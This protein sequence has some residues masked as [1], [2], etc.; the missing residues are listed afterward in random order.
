MSEGGISVGNGSIF[1]DNWSKLG[2]SMILAVC[3][4]LALILIL[5]ISG[6][7]TLTKLNVFDFVFVVALGSVLAS[8]ILSSDTTLADGILAFVVLVGIQIALSWL[9]VTSHTMDSWINGQ[10]T[11]LLHRGKFLQHAMKRERVTKEE[12]LSALRCSH[13][14]KFDEIDA[15][16]LETDGTFSV[17]WRYDDGEKSSLMDVEG[18]EDFIEDQ[19]RAP[20]H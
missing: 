12:V 1:F 11:L 17:V 18:H 14:R 6:K 13:I 16:V 5:R 9:C 7:R 20:G 8:T 15:V 2:R 3:A 10:P 19:K 4:Y